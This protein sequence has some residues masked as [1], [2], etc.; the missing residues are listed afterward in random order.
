MLLSFRQIVLF[1]LSLLVTNFCGN[2]SLKYNVVNCDFLLYD[3]PVLL[4][5]YALSPLVIPTSL[6]DEYILFLLIFLVRTVSLCACSPV[7]VSPLSGL[8]EPDLHSLYALF[9]CHCMPL[10][11]Q[12]FF[13]PYYIPLFFIFYSPPPYSSSSASTYSSHPPT[14]RILLIVHLRFSSSIPFLFPSIFLCLSQTPPL[15]IPVIFHHSSTNR[16][17]DGQTSTEIP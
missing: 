6:C 4:H 15:P 13:G 7:V 12:A 8:Y 2:F 3:H 10:K 9:S 5:S 1:Y 17:L 11:S 16:A 14:V